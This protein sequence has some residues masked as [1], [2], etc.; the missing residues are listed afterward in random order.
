VPVIPCTTKTR[1][2]LEAL[3]PALGFA[4]PWVVEGG[5]ALVVPVGGA[6]RSELPL[7]GAVR[8]KALVHALAEIAAETG[9]SLRGFSRMSLSEL[10]ALTGLSA[11]AAV[12]AS[13][14]E[15]DEPFL[16]EDRRPAL[17]ALK[18]AAERRG[19]TLTRGARFFHLSGPADKGRALAELRQLYA[20]SGG[21]PPIVALG[22]APADL[23]MLLAAE[24]A[25]V[26]PGRD[27]V[28]PELARALPA[29]ERAP[30]PGPL[31]WNSALLLLLEGGRLPLVA[32]DTRRRA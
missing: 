23:G 18:E 26:V 21:A 30:A 16:L 4:G 10:Q 5:A 14:R 19:L 31:G 17:P 2:E 3:A 20:G 22:D 8:R 24:R 11:E 32:D 1:K 9:S 12:R 27:G 29:A 25:I 15:F 6:A 13:D 28:D 7:P